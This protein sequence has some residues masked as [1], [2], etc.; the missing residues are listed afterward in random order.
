MPASFGTRASNNSAA[1]G[2]PPVISRVLED[3]CGIRA[4]TS[5]LPTSWPSRMVITAPTG[6][7]IETGVVVPGMQI[8]RPF[9]S[10]SLTVGRN[11]LEAPE[12]RRLPSITTRVD[13]PVT[14]SV[15]FATVTPSSTFSNFTVPACSVIIGRVCGSQVAKVWPALMASPSCTSRIAP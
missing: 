8:S 14:S 12:E 11:S 2:R 5:P 7:A 15:C 1:R 10:N 4:N 9:S 3:A 13:K 6:N